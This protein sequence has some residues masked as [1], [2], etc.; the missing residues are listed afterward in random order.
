M[1]SVPLF[2]FI[3][4]FPEIIHLHF[5][6]SVMG[7]AY[8]KNLYNI[9]TVHLREYGIGSARQCDDMPYGGG[10]GMVLRPEPLAAAI[11][12]IDD[13]KKIIVYPSAS[14]HL[15]T[16]S[17]ACSLGSHSH[18]VFLCGRYEGID[19]RIIDC[20]V[21]YEL[22]IGNYVLSSG[23]IS[24]IV[25]AD[26]V[27]RGI[28]G[29]L[30]SQSFHEES[31]QNGRVEYPH[32]TRPATWSDMPVPEVLLSGDHAKISAWRIKESL[33]KTI[34]NRPDMT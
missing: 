33:Q 32:Y 6:T 8:R 16:Q 31:H 19:Q 9:K 15:F 13:P 24:S 1:V 26:A 4:L 7:R 27:I 12:S 17:T 3:T 22:C 29:V 11:D 34:Q 25:I 23:E 14:G 10:A 5:S 18:I 21:D 30:N 28:S 2:T 20:Y